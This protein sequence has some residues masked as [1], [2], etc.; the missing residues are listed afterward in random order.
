MHCDVTCNILLVLVY[1]KMDCMHCDVTCYI[2]LVLVHLKKDQ[3]Y[4]LWCYMLYTTCIGQRKEGSNVFIVM[5]HA[6]YHLY[7]STQ[8]RIKCMHCDVTCYI[9]H[10]L[11]HLKKDQVYAL[12]CYMLYT[13][14]TGPPKEGSNVC[15]VMLH[16]I[17]YLYWST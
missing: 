17:Y 2:L 1:L 11:V 15:I 3:V 14:C 7:G 10:V 8:R 4:A 16:A 5:L 6:I 9:L 12:W 13:S